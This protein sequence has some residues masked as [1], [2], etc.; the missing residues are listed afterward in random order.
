MRIK[1]DITINV[2]CP[3]FFSDYNETWI[4]S[5][6][7]QKNSPQYQISWKSVRWESIFVFPV[8]TDGWTE[9][10]RRRDTTKLLVTFRK[11]AKASE[12]SQDSG[13]K[14]LTFPSSN[15]KAQS[16][17][18]RSLRWI[19]RHHR[20]WLAFIGH[21]NMGTVPTTRYRRRI[22]WPSY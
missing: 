16:F 8:H 1:R 18:I 11:F 9:T 12:D 19:S 21:L 13:Q 10:E 5:T 14:R 4:F 7:F 20:R 15:S 2:K 22:L 17:E 6:D 3:L